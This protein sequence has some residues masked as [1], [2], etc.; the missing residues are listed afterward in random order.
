MAGDQIKDKMKGKGVTNILVGNPGGK[1]ELG[2]H[3]RR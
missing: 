1:R 3:W 2:R